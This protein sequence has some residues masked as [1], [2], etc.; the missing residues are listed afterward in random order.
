MTATGIVRRI[1]DL[2]RVVL[3]K[4]LRRNLRL[5]SGTPMEIF[6]ENDGTVRLRKYSPI[7]DNTETVQELAES[8]AQVCGHVVIVTDM[9]TII[10]AAGND[11]LNGKEISVSL[12]TAITA[13]KPVTVKDR[14]QFVHIISDAD[15]P[16][17]FDY[18]QEIIVPIIP[19]GDTEGAVVILT[20]SADLGEADMKVAQMAAAFIGNQMRL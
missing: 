17:A 1:D 6:T 12:E 11:A 18:A 4:E 10:A 14:S 15:V 3:P 7:R 16:S 9:D 13:R 19:E 20:K 8:I 5:R 2:G